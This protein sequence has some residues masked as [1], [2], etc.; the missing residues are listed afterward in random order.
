[1]SKYIVISLSLVV[2][3]IGAATI[4]SK[5]WVT[6]QH[7]EPIMVKGYAE[8]KVSADQGS[9]TVRI[10]EKG[11]DNGEAYEKAGTSLKTVRKLIVDTLGEEAELVELS[12]SL[13][14]T[15]KLN[16]KGNRT[17]EVDYVTATRSL[18]IN[19]SQV[20]KLKTMSRQLYDLNGNGIR[21][22]LS[23]PEFF[24]S[25]LDEVKIDLMKRAT[26]NGRDR[27]EI[28][29]KSSGEKLG[30]LV[31]ARQ[32]V[33]QITKPNSTRTSSYGLYDTETIEKVV[34]LVVTLEFKIGK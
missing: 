19:S 3:L 31:S 25:Q 29:A 33:I 34:K 4:I 7:A 6:I 23:G 22:T 10:S 24:V 1:M 9:L 16:E 27:A 32:G 8:R 5:P 17:N 20:E 11:A 18:R 26:K 14:E 21:L 2:G 12:S 15:K 13:I 28:M 30:S